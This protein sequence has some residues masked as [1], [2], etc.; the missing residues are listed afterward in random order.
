M[1]VQIDTIKMMSEVAYFMPQ[2]LHRA[3]TY[4]ITKDFIE[5]MILES[6]F[7]YDQ[8]GTI[9]SD[10]EYDYLNKELWDRFKDNK[11][12]ESFLPFQKYSRWGA[13]N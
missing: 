12:S 2:L 7:L 9:R 11:F 1:T 8:Y 5:D 4:K 13:N 3:K 10:A 6:P